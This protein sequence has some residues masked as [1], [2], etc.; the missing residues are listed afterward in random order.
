MSVVCWTPLPLI[1]KVARNNFTIERTIQAEFVNDLHSRG[2]PLSERHLST[3]RAHKLLDETFP[4]AEGIHI[5]YSAWDGRQHLWLLSSQAQN[6]RKR[7]KNPQPKAEC[8][9][10]RI[11][12]GWHRK[13]QGRTIIRDDWAPDS[14]TEHDDGFR[15]F[16][17]SHIPRFDQLIPYEPF[18]IYITQALQWLNDHRTYSSCKTH[19]E[20][21]EYGL[22]EWRRCVENRLF[23]LCRY[24]YLYEGAEAGG[25][26]K[27]KPSTPQAFLLFLLDCR[28]NFYMGKGRQA[29]I[30][31]T[32][33]PAL[34]FQAAVRPNQFIK[35]IA[36]DQDTVSD[37]FD[38]KMHF[39]YSVI[40]KEHPW[41][42]PEPSYGG[43]G[44]FLQFGIRPDGAGQ[45]AK[46]TMAAYGS[47][48][49]VDVPKVAAVN[50]GSPDVVYI[51]EA[52]KTPKF[53]DM[54]REVMPTLTGEVDGEMRLKRQLVVVSTGIPESTGE[55][56]RD[57]RTLDDKFRKGIPD[58]I[59]P[60][61]FDWT[62]RPGATWKD[63]E[64][65]RLD[66][67]TGGSQAQN[68]M[69]LEQRRAQF[70]MHWPNDLD[71]MF[72]ISDM[73]IIPTSEIRR[74]VDRMNTAFQK[75]ERLRPK[76]GYFEPRYDTSQPQPNGS[77]FPYK[78]CGATFVPTSDNDLDA[79]VRMWLEPQAGW[80]H[81]YYQGSDPLI[82]DFGSSKMASAIFDAKDEPDNASSIYPTIA[83]IVNY[84]EGDINRAYEQTCL[85]GLAYGRDGS[86]CPELIEANLGK[87]YV[88]FKEQPAI[89]QGNSFL[90][91]RQLPEDLQL[92]Q[93][94]SIGLDLKERRKMSV[95]GYMK[96]FLI[97]YGKNIYIPEIWYQ[98]RTF[99][100]HITA[101]G[102]ERWGPSEKGMCDDILYAMAYAYICRLCHPERKPFN[103]ENMK[104][105][106]TM[107][108]EWYH[109]EYMQL[110]RRMVRIKTQYAA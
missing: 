79:P 102:N 107:E 27:W 61:F 7:A 70:R 31:S 62:C 51:D 37:I 18:Y 88:M 110:R 53:S 82:A 108:E 67:E 40:S 46:T 8:Y 84:R 30:T 90:Y 75:N 87:G 2:L 76:T 60:V 109:D 74:H 25:R 83:C 9:M 77:Y 50:S 10:E 81:R 101:Q 33:A 47:K 42:L 100:K 63:R 86:C 56:E 80:V 72:A 57:L 55:F 104:D 5:D 92:S 69:S 97:A 93:T 24:G 39:P 12:S 6:A 64:E 14:V 16:L 13:W 91:N 28:Y 44:R 11:P 89:Y 95:L 17:S 3:L 71:D 34:M 78:V 73:T 49:Q 52:A 98:V 96:R 26:R 65:A 105:N 41:F 45:T 36:G 32:L 19:R 85:M 15:A 29:A 48:I 20:R 106:Y 103:I 68:D 38:Q 94:N 35:I 66:A 58:K 43:K 4:D 54:A 59:I 99:T 22:E 1:P 23:A 21:I